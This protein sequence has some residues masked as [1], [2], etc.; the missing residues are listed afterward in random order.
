MGTSNWQNISEG[1]E[2]IRAIDPNS[3][4]DIGVGFG[5]WGIL[6][7]E[8]LDI[9]NGN[10]YKDQWE[11]VIDGVEVFSNIITDYHKYFYNNVYISEAYTFL[12]NQSQKYD[13][14]IVGDVLEHFDKLEGRNFLELCI[15]N[16]GYC[17]LNVPIGNNWEQDTLYGNSYEQ[18]KSIWLEEDFDEFQPCIINYYLDYLGRKYN[19]YIFSSK[20]KSDNIFYQKKYIN[21]QINHYNKVLS[22]ISQSY[23]AFSNNINSMFN[24]QNEI[25]DQVLDGINDVYTLSI[26][27]LDTN[28]KYSKGNEL[29]LYDI[30]TDKMKIFNFEHYR[31]NDNCIVRE[32]GISENGHELI[33]LKPGATLDLRIYGNAPKLKVLNHPWSGM[34]EINVKG[35]TIIH[36]LYCESARYETLDINTLLDC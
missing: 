21:Y 24:I 16:S 13:L 30:F 36:D 22:S 18:H 14:I 7:R 6:C 4:L 25:I 32:S 23:C 20:D 17:M 8:F 15:K 2:L 28:N 33:M 27:M 19:S 12:L 34:V 11:R 5:R 26:K 10:I 3:I 1:I 31:K 9:W 29:W 35:K